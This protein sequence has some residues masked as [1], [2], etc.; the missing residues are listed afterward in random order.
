[1]PGCMVLMLDIFCR[2]MNNR[3]MKMVTKH[4]FGNNIEKN[5]FL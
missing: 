1:M 5:K 4:H 3:G 2:D